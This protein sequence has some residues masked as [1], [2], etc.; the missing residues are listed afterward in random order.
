MTNRLFNIAL[1][2]LLIPSLYCC[3]ISNI[4]FNLP[5]SYNRGI[6]KMLTY[7]REIFPDSLIS[8]F[9]T[10]YSSRDTLY[11]LQDIQHSLFA[12]F[13]NVN[14][15]RL[16]DLPWQYGE[17]YVIK[18]TLYFRRIIDNL[19]KKNA[20]IVTDSSLVF[21]IDHLWNQVKGYE[22]WP[23]WERGPVIYVPKSNT[24]HTTE[25]TLIIDYKRDNILADSDFRLKYSKQCEPEGEHGYSCGIT[26]SDVTM[27]I[28]YWIITW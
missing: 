19:R 2:F 5:G 6:N 28:Y 22:D 26:Y 7:S 20:R 16:D 21:T 9:P 27:D 23:K 8:F 13:P 11:T 10:N 4:R 24:Q 1:L 17:R 15:N 25:T 18:D 3:Q 12:S 14:K